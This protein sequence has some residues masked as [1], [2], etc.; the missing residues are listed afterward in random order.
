MFRKVNKKR[1]LIDMRGKMPLLNTKDKDKDKDKD[2]ARSGFTQKF[3]AEKF[4]LFL[5][6]KFV[7]K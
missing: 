5:F 2:K 3:G 7:L 1:E 6:T 4:Q